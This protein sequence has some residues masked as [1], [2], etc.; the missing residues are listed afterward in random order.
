MSYNS[1]NV[2]AVADFFQCTSKTNFLKVCAKN[3]VRVDRI[4]NWGNY[5]QKETTYFKGAF[6]QVPP[7]K[8]CYRSTLF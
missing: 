5:E 4:G 3:P 6:L 1:K 2:R 8:E 7:L